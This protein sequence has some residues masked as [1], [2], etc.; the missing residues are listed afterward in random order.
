MLTVQ[1]MGASNG[2]CCS[3]ISII[4]FDSHRVLSTRKNRLFHRNETG[5]KKSAALS[6]FTGPAQWMSEPRLE[7]IYW[8]LLAL[9]NNVI[10]SDLIVLTRKTASLS[11]LVAALLLYLPVSSWYPREPCY[12][13]QLGSHCCTG[14][15]QT[16]VH[17]DQMSLVPWPKG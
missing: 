5:F 14:W 11:F 1:Q 17:G 8:D 9:K 15:S 6:K 2:L 7:R 13:W 12:F 16:K 3:S 10:S 4:L